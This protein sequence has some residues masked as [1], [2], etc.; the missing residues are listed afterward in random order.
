MDRVFSPG[1]QAA[2]P[3]HAQQTRRLPHEALLLLRVLQHASRRRLRQLGGNELGER[4]LGTEMTPQPR[5]R[6]VM[7]IASEPR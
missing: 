4:V 7:R 3:Q 2:H 5:E 6:V 1:V